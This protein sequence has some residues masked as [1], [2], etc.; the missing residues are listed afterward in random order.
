MTS[1]VDAMLHAEGHIAGIEGISFPH[2]KNN[3]FSTID[4]HGATLIWDNNDI[5]VI[6]K[7]TVGNMGK[8]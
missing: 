4:S 3:F 2:N 6:T 8:T 7:C 5:S 1:T